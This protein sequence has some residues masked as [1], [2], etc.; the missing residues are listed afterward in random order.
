[1]ELKLNLFVHGV[2]KG[3]KIWGPQE[4]DHIFLE[5]FYGRKPNVDVQ[6]LVDIFQFGGNLNC[7]YTYLKGGNILDKDNRPGSYFA[8]TVRVNEYYTDLNNMYNILEAAYQKMILGTILKSNESA[9]RFIVEDFN[10][11]DKQLQEIEK[12]I[13]DYLSSFSISSDFISLSDFAS[14]AKSKASNINLLECNNKNLLNHIKAKGNISVS[15]FYPKMQFVEQ[16]RKKDEEIKNIK[17]QVQ[18]QIA[19]EKKKSE[20]EIQIIKKEYASADKT[21]TELNRQLE[22]EKKSVA[23]LKADLGRNNDKLTDYNTLKQKFSSREHEFN[24]V[25][26]TLS[27]VKQLLNGFNGNNVIIDNTP[28]NRISSDKVHK[29]TRLEKFNK[30]LPFANL[31]VT[32]FI[33]LVVLYSISKISSI[34]TKDI[35]N[36]NDSEFDQIENTNDI[37]YQSP[38]Q[39]TVVSNSEQEYSQNEESK[40]VRIDIKELNKNDSTMIKGKNYHI[41]II[42]VE[43]KGKWKTS[44]F[45]FNKDSSIVI[46]KFKRNCKIDY[47]VNKKVIVSRTFVVVE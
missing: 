42:N 20:Q 12:E 18:Q 35:D 21:I 22:A 41:H 4:S 32:I 5:N 3:Q 19:D 27:G 17:L 28:T 38:N 43:E 6:L 26:N 16:T 33:L 2:P 9:T 39:N 46:P 24:K 14:N 31:I 23:T 29:K 34:Q 13:K 11:V 45:S 25:N 36:Y 44:D 8:L 37:Q 10:Q 15:P 7:Y 30:Y 40:N 47:V 1:M